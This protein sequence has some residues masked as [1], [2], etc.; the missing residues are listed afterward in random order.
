MLTCMDSWG[1][2]RDRRCTGWEAAVSWGGSSVFHSVLHIDELHSDGCVTLWWEAAVSWGGCIVLHS[3]FHCDA[4]H[5]DGCD[6]LWWEAVVSLGGCSVLHSDALHCDG[7]DTQWWEAVVSLRG[8][9]VLH[10]L[11]HS[12]WIRVSL[13]GCSVLHNVLHS[14]SIRGVYCIAACWPAYMPQTLAMNGVVHEKTLVC[15]KGFS[16]QVRL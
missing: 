9:S 12:V 2:R 15:Q 10:S 4:L 3:V 1:D 8:C 6:T 16:V 11:L 13:G 5:S 7:C 14:V